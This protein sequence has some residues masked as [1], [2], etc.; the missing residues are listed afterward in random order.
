M[1]WVLTES[2]ISSKPRFIAATIIS[3]AIS[4]LVITITSF[5]IK[6]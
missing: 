3:F 2:V 1:S 4:A 5:L 6:L